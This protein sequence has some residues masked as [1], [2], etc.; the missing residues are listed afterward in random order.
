MLSNTNLFSL[1]KTIPRYENKCFNKKGY[2]HILD[3]GED[4]VLVNDNFM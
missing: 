4:D 2:L 1:T 3:G